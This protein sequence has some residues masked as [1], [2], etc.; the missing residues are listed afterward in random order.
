MEEPTLAGTGFGGDAIK[1]EA[2]DALAKNEGLRGIE[3]NIL[4]E[5]R[6]RSC[7]GHTP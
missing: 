4:A 6:A 3:E 1:G 5:H 2:A 7:S